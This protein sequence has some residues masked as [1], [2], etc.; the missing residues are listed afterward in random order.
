M[1]G[2][3][4]RNFFLCLCTYMRL[5]CISGTVSDLLALWQGRLADLDTM[6]QRGSGF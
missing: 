5:T 6:P 3:D 4:N 2:M 1:N